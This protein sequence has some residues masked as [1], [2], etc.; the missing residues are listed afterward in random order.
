V[1]KH[2]DQI[3]LSLSFLRC[4]GRAR[5]YRRMPFGS[6]CL[7]F[8]AVSLEGFCATLLNQYLFGARRK[9]SGKVVNYLSQDVVVVRTENNE[10]M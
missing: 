4:D 5:G 1:E 9:N 8:S 7:T 3:F 6:G 2:A 10:I